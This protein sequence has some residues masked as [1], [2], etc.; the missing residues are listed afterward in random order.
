MDHWQQPHILPGIAQAL[1]TCTHTMQIILLW[2][3]WKLVL[4]SC[5]RIL[6]PVYKNEAPS[7]TNA[8]HSIRNLK[9]LQ[10]FIKSS[11]SYNL[12]LNKAASLQHT[13][14]AFRICSSAFSTAGWGILCCAPQSSRLGECTR[15]A[16]CGRTAGFAPGSKSNSV[17]HSTESSKWWASSLSVV[18]RSPPRLCKRI[19]PHPKSIWLSQ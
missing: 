1:A 19:L 14:D 2:M 12:Q 6:A 17:Q 8:F 9:N 3:F 11:T 10:Q 7:P 16:I 5:I 15:E 13:K 18:Q 4:Y